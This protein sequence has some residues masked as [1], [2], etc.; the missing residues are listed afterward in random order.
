MNDYDVSDW[1]TF[2]HPSTGHAVMPSS[3]RLGRCV[4]FQQAGT[5]VAERLS[6]IADV[7]ERIRYLLFVCFDAEER[8]IRTESREADRFLAMLHR[9]LRDAYHA[10][11][12]ALRKDV[13]DLSTDEKTARLRACAATERQRLHNDA[14]PEVDR[15]LDVLDAE[16]VRVEAEPEPI[17]PFEGTTKAYG[18]CQRVIEAY[19]KRLG[20]NE[21]VKEMG[22]LWAE[23]EPDRDKIERS[24]RDVLKRVGITASNGGYESGNPMSFVT[25]VERVVDKYNDQI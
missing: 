25:A 19:H 24:V 14:S 10:K 12:E 11:L 21:P 7:D 5:M 22:D 3:D 1:A 2:E 20:D 15:F 23:L 4:F 17:N 8:Q 18:Y 13:E 16:A 6:W 9:R